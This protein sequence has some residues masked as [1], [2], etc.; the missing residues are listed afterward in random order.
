MTLQI[1]PY[2]SA[3][4]VRL[5]AP[6][7]RLPDELLLTICSYL[8]NPRALANTRLICRRLYCI[9]SD[10]FLW[11][12]H[13][14][15]PLFAPPRMS[16]H[17]VY[18]SERSGDSLVSTVARGH[19]DNVNCVALDVGAKIIVS[20]SRDDT[21]KVWDLEGACK[22]TLTGH[23]SAVECLAL[24]TEAKII[25]S[26]SGD[27]TLKVWDLDGA[28]KVTLTGHTGWVSCVALDSRSKIVV[29][30][31]EDGTLRIWDPEEGVCKATLMEHTKGHRNWV[32]S[33]ALDAGAKIIVSGS[34]DHTL[35]VWQPSK[36][37]SWSPISK[38]SGEE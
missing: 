29:S 21:L 13:I 8:S 30:G 35:R 23:T 26:G 6:I 1:Q 17:H 9:A 12:P 38:Q 27:R 19:R 7:L 34:W 5:P 37:T 20:G 11:R 2:A 3:A 31:S 15:L 18:L 22:A 32:T 24:D 16:A 14:H 25:V 4:A 10:N 28:Y 36:A 33:V